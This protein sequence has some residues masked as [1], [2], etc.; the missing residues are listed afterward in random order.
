[1]AKSGGPPPRG[2][3]SAPHSPAAEAAGRTPPRGSN[4]PTLP[5]AETAGGPAH[6]GNG[7]RYGRPRRIRASERPAPTS[8]APVAAAPST[9]RP[10]PLSQR[11]GIRVTFGLSASTGGNHPS[12]TT[13]T[14]G[15]QPIGRPRPPATGRPAHRAATGIGAGVPRCETVAVRGSS[16]G[17]P[18][19][20][21]GAA[22]RGWHGAGVP[23]PVARGPAGGGEA[24]PRRIGGRSRVPGQVRAGGGRGPERERHVHG[25]S[26][27]RGPGGATAVAGHRVRA[28]PIPGRHRGRPGPAAPHICADT[29]GRAGGGTWGDPCRGH[30]SP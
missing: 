28:R 16:A 5:A 26:S 1:M 24:D 25:T 8:R 23:G 12:T 29:G 2:G 4:R 10:G 22:G 7:T 27:G 13:S 3:S 14:P 15:A 19:P 6:R 9:L 11:H 20:P 21:A 30:G 17:R 18:V